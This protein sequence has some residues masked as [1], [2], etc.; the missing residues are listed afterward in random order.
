M[1]ITN[2]IGGTAG[3]LA[4]VGILYLHGCKSEAPV[5]PTPP[6]ADAKPT[7]KTAPLDHWAVPAPAPAP[8]VVAPVHTKAGKKVYHRVLK[9]GKLDGP[10]QCKDV[11]LLA[12]QAPKDKVLAAAKEYG[13]TPKQ[14]ADLRVCLN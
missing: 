3:A 8:V 7:P 12:K 5:V 10:V 11:P 4:L 1:S 6:H 14:L 13:L 2:V 9:G